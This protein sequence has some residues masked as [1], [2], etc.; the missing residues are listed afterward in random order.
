MRRPSM[1]C[2]SAHMRNVSGLDFMSSLVLSSQ[3]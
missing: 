3:P 2:W 1:P